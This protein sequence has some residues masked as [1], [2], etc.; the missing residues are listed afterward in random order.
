PLPQQR[1]APDAGALVSHA[2]QSC[3]RLSR[4]L[5]ISAA[6][7]GCVITLAA[8]KTVPWASATF[9]GGRHVIYLA[10]DAGEDLVRWAAGLPEAVLPLPG[11][12][13]ADL[14]VSE[15]NTL[16]GRSHFSIEAL[17]VEAA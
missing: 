6:A 4:P 15:F 14:V 10:A 11:H 16:S 13:L 8:S 17:T 3:A 5:A 2:L 9:T 12:M 7:A 1:H